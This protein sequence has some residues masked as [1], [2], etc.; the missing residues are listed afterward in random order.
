M[1]RV[2]RKSRNEQ[3]SGYTILLTDDN[4][5]YL[6]VTRRLLEREGHIVVTAS[7]GPEAITVLKQGKIDLLLLDYY[8]P[9]MTG[10][11]VVTEL[12]QFNP[13]VQVILQTGYASEQP[14]RALLRRLDIQGYYDKSEGPDKLLLWTEVGLK[15]AYVIQLLN[16]SRQGLR[17]ILDVTP[18][19]HKIQSLADLLQGIL[20]Q[21]TGLLGASSSFLALLPEGGVVRQQPESFLAMMEE[22]NE[23]VIRASTGRFEGQTTV[24]TYLHG[25]KLELVRKA[26]AGGDILI[27]QGVTVVPLRVS[28]ATIGI[29]YL[30]RAAVLEQDIE[31][32]HIFAN[33][34]AVAIQNAQL[35]EMATL[36]QLTGAFL[37]RFFE[38]WMLRELRTAF[39]AQHVVSLLVVDMDG[40]KH[41]NDTAGH[42]GGDQALSLVGKSLREA[43]R[44]SDIVGRYGGD[45]F[46]IVLP[47]TPVAGAER[48]ANRILQLVG[49]KSVPG[50]DGPLP[51]RISIG[52][53]VLDPP[54]TTPS[55]HSRPTSHR[56]YQE[57]AK[58]LFQRAD[59]GLYK[60]KREGGHKL[61]IGGN[62]N[63]SDVPKPADGGPPSIIPES[64]GAA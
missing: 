64:S 43:V 10:E 1:L 21:V 28:D 32:L 22:D 63:W 49:E 53:A 16:K 7:S 11:Q 47:Q 2:T 40:M 12:R 18:D 55:D 26:V 50:P 59:E 24:E 31:L 62:L 23:L 56:Y 61:S 6:Q 29:I 42:L 19:M 45:E 52:L 37:R 13:F 60:S 9:G 17:Y 4:L 44:T 54:T 48:V 25:E 57:V 15:A 34:A 36:D 20:L 38:Q 14:P 27:E 41:I 3:S 30:D 58:A 46:A 39:R 35:Y 5:D 33:Q 8:M 51:L